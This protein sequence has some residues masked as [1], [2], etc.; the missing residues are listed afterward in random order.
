[1]SIAK[2]CR[3]DAVDPVTCIDLEVPGMASDAVG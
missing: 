1:M 3:L 2:K